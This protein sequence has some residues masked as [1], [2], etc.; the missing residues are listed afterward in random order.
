[1]KIETLKVGYLQENCYIVTKDEKT[2][3]IDPGDEADRIL[4]ACKDKSVVGILLTHDHFD[5]VGALKEVEEKFKLKVTTKVENFPFEVIK[6]PGHTT[7]SLTYYFKEDGVMFTGD[8]LFKGTI[9]RMD[10]PTGSQ[11]DMKKSLEL[12]R[13]YP[14]ETKVY[15]GHGPETTLGIEIPYFD[16]YINSMWD[17]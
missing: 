2:I 12:I 3:I 5:H 15:P 7:D 8:F 13:T 16:D 6:T 11:K 1:M 10:L 14:M 17:C 4:E 9:G